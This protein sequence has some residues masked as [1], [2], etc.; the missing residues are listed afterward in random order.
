[1][2]G[3]VQ[4]TNVVFSSSRSLKDDIR[5]L[6]PQDVLARLG[7]LLISEWRFKQGTSAVRH[8]GPMA[9]DFHAAFGL[10][11]DGETLSVTDVSGVALA[12]IQALL[13]RV[14]KLEEANRELSERLQGLSAPE[15]KDQ[16]KAQQ[17]LI[18]QLEERLARLEGKP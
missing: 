2:D 16:I 12:A 17:E 9:E 7:N 13:Q 15:Q 8:V 6:N 5:P 11:A 10:G 1:V 3:S 14:R 4:A 18:R